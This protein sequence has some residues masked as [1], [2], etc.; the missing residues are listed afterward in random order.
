MVIQWSCKDLSECI[1]K[2]AC[3]TQTNENE[4]ITKNTTTPNL[5]DSVK[6]VL[7]GRFIAKQAYLKKQREISNKQPNFTSKAT[8][9]RRIP[10]LQGKKS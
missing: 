5:R 8:R 4:N 6:T 1:L 10:K 2:V 9:K 3:Y 7:R